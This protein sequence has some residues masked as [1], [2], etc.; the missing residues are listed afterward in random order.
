MVKP[1]PIAFA[2]IA[3]KIDSEKKY[4]EKEINE[5]IKES[6]AFRDAEK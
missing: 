3:E 1:L 4:S 6:I 2:R 5:I